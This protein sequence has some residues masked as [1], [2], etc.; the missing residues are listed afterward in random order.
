MPFSEIQLKVLSRSTATGYPSLSWTQDD[1]QDEFNEEVYGVNEIA[2][3]AG[4]TEISLGSIA[5]GKL[6]YI[7]VVEDETNGRESLEIRINGS[8]NDAWTG[9][10]FAY[11]ADDTTGVTS[12][13]LT[14]NNSNS[15]K[16]RYF[17][18]GDIVS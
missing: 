8:G 10:T 16:Y 3:G 1:L 15:V 18:A 17:I 11:E 5:K 13:H 6:V 2:A 12:I 9:T 4:P 7:E 14:N